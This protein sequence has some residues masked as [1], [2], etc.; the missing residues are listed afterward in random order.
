MPLFRLNNWYSVPW[1]QN[2]NRFSRLADSDAHHGKFVGIAGNHTP[3]KLGAETSVNNN[4]L[5]KS[6]SEDRVR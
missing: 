2:A 1:G 6:Q 5:R 4:N 3:G